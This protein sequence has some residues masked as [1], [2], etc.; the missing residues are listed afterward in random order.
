MSN[1]REENK[2]KYYYIAAIISII[3]AILFVYKFI[4]KDNTGVSYYPLTLGVFFIFVFF[5]WTLV[6]AFQENSPP[7]VKFFE[8]VFSNISSYQGDQEVHVRVASNAQIAVKTLFNKFSLLFLALS[9]LLVSLSNNYW[10]FSIWPLFIIF[11]FSINKSVKNTSS[12]T[13]N[14]FQH[15]QKY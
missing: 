2:T 9:I 1:P 11:G 12:Y 13:D 5:G 6:S 8:G 4:T 10:Y 14:H 7:I 15:N 3:F